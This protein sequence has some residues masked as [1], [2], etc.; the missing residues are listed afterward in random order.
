VEAS[1][2]AAALLCEAADAIDVECVM[3]NIEEPYKG[4][5]EEMSAL[6][7]QTLHLA[8]ANSFVGVVSYPI[9]SYHPT[10]NWDAITGFDFGS[11][12]F[13]TTA[14]DPVAVNRGNREWSML[15]PQVVPSLDGWSGTGVEG[16]SRFRGDIMRVCGATTPPNLPGA[17]VWSESQMDDAKRAVTRDMAA[18]YSWPTP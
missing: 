12:M 3:L 9:P 15:V 14:Q 10:L 16:A 4:K 5:T 17:I 6:C 11:P 2:S 18:T 8:P 7:N 13:Y 1:N